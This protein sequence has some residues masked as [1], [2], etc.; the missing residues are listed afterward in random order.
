MAL[1]ALKGIVIVSKF[2]GWHFP[3][4]RKN[5]S[6]KYDYLQQQKIAK[7]IPIGP[8]ARHLFL[9]L[10]F[11]KLN[12]ICSMIYCQSALLIAEAVNDGQVGLPEK[13]TDETFFKRSSNSSRDDDTFLVYLVVVFVED[14][15]FVVY[16]IWFW[17]LIWPLGTFMTTYYRISKY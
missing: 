6:E 11:K 15:H 17:L 1:A 9:K 2:F 8:L 13:K 4:E 7:N 10:L 14:Q 12:S 16:N 3:K 5:S